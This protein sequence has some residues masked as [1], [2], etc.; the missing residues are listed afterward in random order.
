[1][2]EPL[3]RIPGNLT[4]EREN[5]NERSEPPARNEQRR[6]DDERG[7][8]FGDTSLSDPDRPRTVDPL[9]PHKP[10]RATGDP[11][12]PDGHVI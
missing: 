5:R 1:M 9:D 6:D 4:E 12:D 2:G 10:G 7:G 11:L 8:V 3:S